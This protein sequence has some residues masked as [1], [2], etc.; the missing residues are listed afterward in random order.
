MNFLKQ[1]KRYWVIPI[2]LIKDGSCENLAD[3]R[4][5]VNKKADKGSCVVAWNIND[6]I[7]EAES[8]LKNELIYKKILS[9][10]ICYVTY[11]WTDHLRRTLVFI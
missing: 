8:Q 6:Y 2:F 3:Y 7:K 11:T 1:K 5:I 4:N 9:N 10:G